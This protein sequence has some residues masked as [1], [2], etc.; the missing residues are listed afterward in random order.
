M[1]LVASA[2]SSA[3]T[4]TRFTALSVI[5]LGAADSFHYHVWGTST[6]LVL[7]SGAAAALGVHVATQAA[8]KAAAAS[9]TT[10]PAGG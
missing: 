3:T 5:G 2:I 7:I 9:S 4:W 8:A 10:P 6:D 1:N